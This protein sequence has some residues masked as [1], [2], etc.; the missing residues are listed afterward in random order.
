MK[1]TSLPKLKPREFSLNQV[2]QTA[3]KAHP[4]ILAALEN[5]NQ[6]EVDLITTGL[7]P[8]AE[9]ARLCSSGR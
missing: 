2:I 7:L 9:N 1:K 5:I 8:N 6:A 4:V 3:F